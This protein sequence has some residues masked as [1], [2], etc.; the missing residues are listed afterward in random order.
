MLAASQGAGLLWTLARVR[1]DPELL[2]FAY[3]LYRDG[4]SLAGEKAALEMLSNAGECALRLASVISSRSET[5]H[6][7]AVDLL[8][9]A[10]DHLGAAIRAL[11]PSSDTPSPNRAIV[12]SMLGEVLGPRYVLTHDAPDAHEAIVALNAAP[13]SGGD[14]RR[15]DDLLDECVLQAR[16]KHGV[17]EGS[18]ERNRVEAFGGA[19]G[20]GNEGDLARLCG[21]RACP[22]RPRRRRG[23]PRRTRILQ[24]RRPAAGPLV[25]VAGAATGPR[26]VPT[27]SRA[28][29]PQ[30][31]H[32]L[33][34]NERHELGGHV[35]TSCR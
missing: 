12:L 18:A 22:T 30:A 14:T 6:E 31:P 5:D 10:R 34:S 11:D 9:E 32:R 35:K 17:R 28:G 15:I 13:E 19:P 25:A 26:P 23:T 33:F 7:E 3:E 8:A 21:R 4:I 29:T 20:P 27:H 24:W 16:P 2:R 1:A